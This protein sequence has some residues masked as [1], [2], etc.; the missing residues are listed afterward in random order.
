VDQDGEPIANSTET[1]PTDDLLLK[2]AI[3]VVSAK[4]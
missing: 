4:S 3:E 2:K 1:K